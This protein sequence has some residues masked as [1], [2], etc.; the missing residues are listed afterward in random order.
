MEKE[1]IPDIYTNFCFEGDGPHVKAKI[2][3]K[4]DLIHD[5]AVI[6]F[7]GAC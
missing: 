5:F 6:T 3:F 7:A 4:H 2:M 1:T